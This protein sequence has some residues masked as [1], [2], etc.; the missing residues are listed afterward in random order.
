M[1]SPAEALQASLGSWGTCALAQLPPHLHDREAIADL[2][3]QIYGAMRYDAD[4]E[5]RT[6]TPEHTYIVIHVLRTP[7]THTLAP[8]A[9]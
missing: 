2:L 3:E 6:D 5:M 4:D 7:I 1:P 8:G 9:F